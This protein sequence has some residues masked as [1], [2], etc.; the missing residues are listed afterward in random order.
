MN[1][2]ICTTLVK[3]MSS[4][5]AEA[6]KFWR[7]G[8]PARGFA[9]RG[10]AA[11]AAHGHRGDLPPPKAPATLPR[12]ASEEVCS[13]TTSGAPQLDT[14]DYTVK[15]LGLARPR[16]TFIGVNPR[17]T[18]RAMFARPGARPT[19]FVLSWNLALGVIHGLAAL[20]FGAYFISLFSRCDAT[21]V[22]GRELIPGWL[23]DHTDAGS[24]GR[25]L[26]ISERM[27]AVLVVA[28]FAITSAAHFVYAAN[29]GGRY[30]DAVAAGR[31]PWRW[32][33]YGITATIMTAI[34]ATVSGV[35]DTDAYF[36]LLVATACMIATGMW[37]EATRHP[38][39]LVV[40]FALLAWIYSTIIRSFIA[41]VRE[42]QRL[43]TSVPSFV[44]AIVV[45]ILVF[46]GLFGIVPV[47]QW[48]LGNKM[49]YYQAEATYLFLSLASKLTLGALMAWGIGGRIN[50]ASDDTVAQ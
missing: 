3:S 43:G 47:L 50:A 12:L 18:A 35:R 6:Q 28:F 27:L 48:A 31:M 41:R 13:L 15:R 9:A 21:L 25:T 24:A 45:T 33:E 8:S 36:G 32:I 5:Y 49:P 40:G 11:H 7:D 26:R 38:L 19:D 39:A 44:Y 10:F 42:S 22:G 20:V 29:P 16:R 4:L 46:F 2:F 1:Q 17:V 30:S 34:V 23:Y 37:W 14:G